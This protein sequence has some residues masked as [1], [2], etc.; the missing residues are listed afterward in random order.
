MKKKKTDMSQG[1][2]DLR[3]LRL[4]RGGPLNGRDKMNRK[5]VVSGEVFRLIPT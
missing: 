5:Q 3:I 2:L 1:M 4:L